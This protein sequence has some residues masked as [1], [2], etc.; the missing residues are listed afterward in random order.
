MKKNFLAIQSDQ[1]KFW[2]MFIKF[3]NSCSKNWSKFYKLNIVPEL[4]NR[5]NRLNYYSLFLGSLNN[6]TGY[7]KKY[8]LTFFFVGLFFKNCAKTIIESVIFEILDACFIQWYQF[9]S[10]LTKWPLKIPMKY[11]K[12]G[13]N[14][15]PSKTCWRPCKKSHFSTWPRSITLSFNNPLLYYLSANNC[16]LVTSLSINDDSI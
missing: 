2:I 10:F 5:L 16:V 11:G 7:S 3:K 1:N 15:V 13:Q 9:W 12:N 14:F 8:Q 6:V 4:L